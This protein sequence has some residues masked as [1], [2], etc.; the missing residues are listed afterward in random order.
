[1]KITK[2]IIPAAGLGTRFL[3]YT[4]SVPKELLPIMQTPAFQFIIEE[5]L[6]SGICEFEIIENE[7]KQAIN[8]Y[9]SKNLELEHQ[10][11]QTNKLSSIESINKIIEQATFNYIPQKEPLGL[12]HAILMAKQTIDNEYF[13]ILLPDEIMMG[14]QAALAQL[15]SIAQKYNTSVIAVQEVPTEKVSSYG[16]ISIKNQ[17]ENN[18]F[19][20]EQLVEKPAIND[21]P[22]NLAIIGRYILSSSLFNSLE[23]I[24]PGA[25]NEIQ[26]TDGIAHMIKNGEKVLAYKIDTIRHDIGNPL[27]W[28]QANIYYSISNPV[29]APL[30]KNIYKILFKIKNY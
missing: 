25:N 8:N 20:I 26:L 2:A 27:G 29:T 7:N 19:E 21:T 16:I 24:H 23:N 22:S 13:G 1:M 3:P 10:L 18:L 4:K 11:Q 14:K 28:L 12:G 30:I 15:I 9:F 6:E 17:L 5:G